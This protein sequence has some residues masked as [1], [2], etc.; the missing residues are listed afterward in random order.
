VTIF[1]RAT[2]H[3]EFAMLVYLCYVLTMQAKT[4]SDR[5]R[6]FARMEYI[7]P[8]RARHESSVRAKSKKRCVSTIGYHSFA[9]R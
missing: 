2:L 1:D 8:A 4:D 5:V 3:A 6:E 7:E 9:K